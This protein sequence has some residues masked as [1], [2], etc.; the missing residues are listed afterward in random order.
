MTLPILLMLDMIPGLSR[1]DAIGMHE[2]TLERHEL[3][4]GHA[5]LLCPLQHNS[6]AS[7]HCS[8]SLAYLYLLGAITAEKQLLSDKSSLCEYARKQSQDG[9][10]I[11][12]STLQLEVSTCS[13]FQ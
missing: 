4:Q 13:T 6:Q 1:H 9:A 2:V 10:V 8:L 3:L 5:L 7:L 12:Q 11:W